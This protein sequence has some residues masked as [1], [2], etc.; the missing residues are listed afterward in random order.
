MPLENINIEIK[1]LLKEE[2]SRLFFIGFGVFLFILFFQPFPLEM[3]DYNNR[4]LF[5]TG[6]GV[7]T[8]ICEFITFIIIPLV[9]PKWFKISEWESGP[10]FILGLIFLMFSYTS[11]AFFIR[12][13]GMVYLSLY[14]LLKIFLV[15]LLPLIVIIILYK[16]KSLERIITILKDQNRF[17][18]NKINE[19]EQLGIEHEI[20]FASENKSDNL[21]LNYNNII[22]IKSADNYIEINYLNNEVVEKKLLRSTLKNIESQLT[23]QKNIIRCHRTTLINSIYIEKMLRNYSGFYLKMKYLEENIPVSRQYSVFIKDVINA[24]Q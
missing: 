17:Y 4:L 16:N 13:V 5:V 15:C 21:T 19:F 6:F 8:F 18:I 3:L 24:L 9:I 12:Y 7:I 11:Y 1:T 23:N 20:N 10:P 14:I 2:L 22:T